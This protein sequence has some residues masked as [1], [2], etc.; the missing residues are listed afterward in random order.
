MTSP[1]SHTAGS[2]APVSHSRSRLAPGSTPS[3]TELHAL[4]SSTKSASD[5][6]GFPRD[7]L[8]IATSNL[9]YFAL[10]KNEA[11]NIQHVPG[12]WL[13]NLLWPGEDSE[14]SL[15]FQLPPIKSLASVLVMENRGPRAGFT[16]TAHPTSSKQNV[17]Q[18][19]FKTNTKEGLETS[20]PLEEV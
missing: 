18:E 1:V 17:I 2:G 15:K 4:L 5:F 14:F 6:W 11:G 8:P 20:M 9:L 16:A 19:K 7:T 3:R 13:L 10:A 12:S